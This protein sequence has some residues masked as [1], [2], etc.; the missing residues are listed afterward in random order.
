MSQ[1]HPQDISAALEWAVRQAEA[2]AKTD[3]L[4][5]LMHL[6]ALRSLRDQAVRDSRGGA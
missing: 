1:P 6:P 3:D 4:V 5:R 2:K